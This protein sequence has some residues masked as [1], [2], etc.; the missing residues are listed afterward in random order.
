MS[1]VI[2]TKEGDKLKVKSPYHPDFP[3]WAK[4]LG[5]KWRDKCWIFAVRDEDSVRDLCHTCYGTD[6]ETEI[7][8]VDVRIKIRGG[9]Q[10]VWACGRRIAYRPERDSDVILGENVI[11]VSGDF[12][13]SGGSRRS[14]IIE[15]LGH[16]PVVL[17]VRNVPIDMARSVTEANPG[18]HRIVGD[19]PNIERLSI[20]VL[21]T[22]IE[23]LREKFSRLSDAEIVIAALEYYDRH[24][25]GN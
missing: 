6:G 14:P 7:E 17:E 13:R 24:T 19:V 3:R 23:K 2:V 20:L 18:S 12:T 9:E 10:T 11:V 25:D 22:I 4:R 8:T 15:V 5:G 16:E 21:H 1:D